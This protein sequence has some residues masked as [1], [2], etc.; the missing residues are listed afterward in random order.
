[1]KIRTIFVPLVT[2]FFNFEN[3]IVGGIR[4][5]YGVTITNNPKAYLCSYQNNIF[6]SLKYKG[7]IF[8]YSEISKYPTLFYALKYALA[9]FE[10][11]K[12]ETL[13]LD[14]LFKLYMKDGIVLTEP[15]NIRCDFKNLLTQKYM[16][17][18]LV[19][20]LKGKLAE[21][22]PTVKLKTNIFLD[23]KELSEIYAKELCK[24]KFFF[25]LLNDTI[26]ATCF[27][28]LMFFLI[29]RNDLM[30]F[31]E[32]ILVNGINVEQIK[33]FGLHN[34]NSLIISHDKSPHEQKVS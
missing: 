24:Q 18:V 22:P 16:D 1:M 23:F 31:I 13:S 34:K 2:P 3:K 11:K 12:E 17:Y 10:N 32:K 33:V 5:Y 7:N 19:S 29:S 30:K 9:I 27:G 4:I 20:I 28:N 8:W 6:H 25:K 15:D 21:I 14:I 26:V